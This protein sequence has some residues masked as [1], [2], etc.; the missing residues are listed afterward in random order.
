MNV[1]ASLGLTLLS[2][3]YDSGDVGSV[4]GDLV[5]T[6]FLNRIGL[7]ALVAILSGCMSFN[8]A[9]QFFQF[10]TM[11]AKSFDSSHRVVCI[12]WLDGFGFLCSAP[13]WAATAH[14]VP[15]YGWST[16]WALWT[17]L[18]AGAWTLSLRALPPILIME[19][20]SGHNASQ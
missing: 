8:V 15:Q 4:G 12:S 19:K 20:E 3:F 16:A 5:D 7:A 6:L 2:Y 11:I 9:Y 13:I 1:G 14:I 10:P 17:V 18:V